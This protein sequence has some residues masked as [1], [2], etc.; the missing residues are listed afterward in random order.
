MGMVALVVVGTPT[1][2]DDA[3]AVPQVGKAKQVMAG[4]FDRLT[5]QTAQK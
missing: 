1:N 5:S 3:K 4:L 2:F